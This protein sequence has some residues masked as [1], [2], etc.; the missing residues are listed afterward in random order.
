MSAKID[1]NK[2]LS[3]A[4]MRYLME[5]DMHDQVAFNS[6]VHGNPLP[7]D[8][9]AV[10]KARGVDM[11]AIRRRAVAAG[12]LSDA[13]EA[14]EKVPAAP[15]GSEGGTGGPN[16]PEAGSGE[17][18]GPSKYSEEWFNTATVAMLKEE[19]SQPDRNLSTTG[20]KEDLADRLWSYLVDTGVIKEDED[21]S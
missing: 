16:A 21:G 3:D 10:M 15:E 4:D 1:L 8:V 11:R 20:K 9:S 13:A 2:P 5:R 19:L 17:V 18:S 12:K 7:D 6:M 14:A